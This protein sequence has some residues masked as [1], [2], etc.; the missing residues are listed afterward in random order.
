MF[1]GHDN[2]IKW[3]LMAVA[4][5]I[6]ALVVF[7]GIAWFDQPLYLF[8]RQF[9]CGLWRVL[10]RALG[11]K[12]WIIVSTVLVILVYVKKAVHAKIKCRNGQNKF[13]MRAVMQDGWAK[14][15]NSNAFLVLCAVAATSVIVQILKVVIGRVRPVFFEA[16]DMTGF[17]PFS[18]NWEFNSMPSG[19][20]AAS[21][22]GLVMIGMLA[23][24]FK[25]LT[26]TAAVIIGASRVCYGAHWPTDV[27]LGA[28]IGMVMA[29]LVLGLHRRLRGGM[30]LKN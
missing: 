17:F 18:F 1:L 24:K 12:S 8:M 30:P 11:V 13:S 4:S 19:H 9:D 10:D 6:V 26:W 27:V 25:P 22:A 20:T 7:A 23:P 16:L 2:R 5:V 14:I 29:D 28:F 21:F 3:K 15:K